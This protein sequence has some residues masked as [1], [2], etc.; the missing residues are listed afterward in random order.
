MYIDEWRFHPALKGRRV[1]K[2]MTFATNYSPHN[3]LN[4]T[5]RYIARKKI[6]FI[7]RNLFLTV[8]IG[9]GKYIIFPM[10]ALSQSE[11]LLT[12][13]KNKRVHH[14]QKMCLKQ[15]N[16]K[17]LI[18]ASSAVETFLFDQK[19]L[20]EIFRLNVLI[21]ESVVKQRMSKI[22]NCFIILHVA[23]LSRT[24]ILQYNITAIVKLYV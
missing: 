9:E 11:R 18:E 20:K 22:I 6:T 3:L 4:S 21:K 17:I 24:R 12:P 23:R 1:F 2:K 8:L 19:V 14:L 15:K 10:G 16:K 5:P 7:I 13:N